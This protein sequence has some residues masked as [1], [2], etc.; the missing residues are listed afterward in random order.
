MVDGIMLTIGDDGIARE[1]KDDFDIT[2]HCESK[3]E[4]EEIWKRLAQDDWTSCSKELPKEDG[5][6]LVTLE[7]G[8]A[9]DLGLELIIIMNFEADCESFGYWYERFDP[10][11]LGSLGDDWMEVPVTAWKPLPEPYRGDQNE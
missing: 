3:E 5:D 8:Y 4:Q 1:Y 2:I 9:E 10:Y 6:Y 11:T 7:E